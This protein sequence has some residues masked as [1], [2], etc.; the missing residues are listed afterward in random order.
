MKAFP[1]LGGNITPTQTGMDLRDY[2]AAQALPGLLIRRWENEEGKVPDNVH[3]LWAQAAYKL[4][5]EMLAVRDD[6]KDQ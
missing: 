2:F 4:A 3:K 1:M 5:D 6:G